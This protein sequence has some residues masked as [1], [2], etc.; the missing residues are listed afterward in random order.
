YTDLRD[1]HSFPYTTLFR[2]LKCGLKR[3][4]IEAI[5]EF[6]E[7]GISTT[8]IGKEFNVTDK[9]IA[10]VLVDNGVS[11]RESGTQR[12]IIN[13]NY[14]E[15]IDTE[16]KAYFL[17]LIIADGSIIRHLSEGRSNRQLSISLELKEQDG[18]MVELF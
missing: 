17:G 2:S 12:K 6:Y 14:F 15:D 4:D 18:Y 16:E 13:D 1:L 11:L 7:A 9:T 10:K 3:K 8:N 5:K